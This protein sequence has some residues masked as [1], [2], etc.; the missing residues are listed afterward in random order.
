MQPFY[1]TQCNCCLQTADIIMANKRVSSGIILPFCGL[2]FVKVV[3]FCASLFLFYE[4]LREME[5]LTYGAG[6]F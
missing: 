5:G 4:S 1:L 2:L 3:V 6:E